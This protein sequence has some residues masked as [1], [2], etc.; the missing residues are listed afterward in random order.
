MIVMR[1][2]AILLSALAAILALAPATASAAPRNCDGATLVS[3]N[4]VRLSNGSGTIAGAIQ[5]CR[6]GT[7]WFA[8]YIHYSIMSPERRGVGIL[9][10]WH[11][12]VF[13]ASRSCTVSPGQTWCKT[14]TLPGPDNSY[15][16]RGAG[17]YQAW[18]SGRWVTIGEGYTSRCNLSGCGL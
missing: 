13:D 17:L 12:G 11:N 4:Y 5:L 16:F 2:I 7:N 10:R 8:M 15:W 6:T 1:R 9:Q 18:Q 14:T 3:A